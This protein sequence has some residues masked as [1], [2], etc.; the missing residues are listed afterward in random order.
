ME[1]TVV[2]LVHNQN[3]GFIR[4]DKGKEFFFHRTD[5]EGFWQDMCADHASGKVEVKVTFK[6]SKTS[7][8]PRAIEISRLDF[9]NQNP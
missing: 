6:E 5:F 8:G 4:N 2:R 1:G 3:F 9:P 7:R